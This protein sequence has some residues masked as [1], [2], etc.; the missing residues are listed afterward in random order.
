MFGFWPLH[1]EGEAQGLT[2]LGGMRMRPSQ[3]RGER[4]PGLIPGLCL[5]DVSLE[6]PDV[7]G[8]ERGE[9]LEELVVESP[10]DQPGSFAVPSLDIF[11]VFPKNCF[12]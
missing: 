5:G 7:T 1:S 4:E 3:L 9:S 11:F 6:N 12:S 10:E 2:Q 8:G